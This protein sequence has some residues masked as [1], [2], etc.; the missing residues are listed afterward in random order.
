MF[1][2]ASKE[3]KCLSLYYLLR[4]HI[5]W[6]RRNFWQFVI[7]FAESNLRQA[8]RCVW[9]NRD[10]S[11]ILFSFLLLKKNTSIVW[12]TGIDKT[13]C[14]FKKVEARRKKKGR[15]C[16]KRKGLSVFEG[17]LESHT[18]PMMAS[19]WPE[20]NKVNKIGKSWSTYCKE[21]A[22]QLQAGEGGG[23]AGSRDGRH[24]TNH[25]PQFTR[26]RQGLS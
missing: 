24:G 14:T 2:S 20:M 13:C 9:Y 25:W 10:L 26:S 19:S 4:T 21:K 11:R 16:K 23:H 15:N 6:R 8:C 18:G 7:L 17:Q 5:R 1:F 3:R 22:C 12:N